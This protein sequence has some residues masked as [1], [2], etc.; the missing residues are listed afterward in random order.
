[1]RNPKITVIMSVYN[2]EKY[3]NKAVDS[4]LNQSLED[5]E[6]ILINDKSTD[7][8]LDILKDY[9]SKDDRITL[10]NNEKNLGLGTS[11]NNALKIAKGEYISFVDGD[12][13]ILEDCLETS[14]MEAK[15][16]NTDIT[17]FQMTNYNNETGEYHE[18]NWSNLDE[19]EDNFYNRAFNPEETKDFLFRLPVSACQKIYRLQYLK[20]IDAQFPDR[21][22][23]EDNPFFYYVWLNADR[24]SLIKKHFYIRRVHPGSITGK[25]DRKFFD[26]IPS[27]V[28]LSRLMIKSGHYEE[29]KK[30]LI[31][32]RI[33]AYRLT[34][35]CLS[36][37]L[38]EEF[39]RRSKIQF[40][41]ILESPY[42]EDFLENM[43]EKN[44][45]IFYEILETEN[46]DEFDKRWPP[47]KVKDKNKI[48]RFH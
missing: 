7:S 37:E 22:Y 1:M 47:S 25:C 6:V 42:R 9:A 12:D 15:K 26:I 11:R 43:N 35:K 5:I 31:N 44:N 19:L 28:A 36:P 23:F 3:L 30:D 38:K 4:I 8:S 2:E 24:I 40:N 17:M 34:M 27:G 39:Y 16:F 32:Y 10:I 46:F 33:D 20:D 45:R 13:W 18:N 14:Y 48:L 29:Y 21:I 41:K